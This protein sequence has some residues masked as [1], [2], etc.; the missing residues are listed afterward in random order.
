M[1]L[2]ED[3]PLYLKTQENILDL[4][5]GKRKPLTIGA[6]KRELGT[7]KFLADALEILVFTGVVAEEG[8]ILLPTYKYIGIKKVG[9]ETKVC[10]KCLQEKPLIEF[11]QEWAGSPSRMCKLC[12]IEAQKRRGRKPKSVGKESSTSER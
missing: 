2:D 6:I 9:L 5:K 1:D 7:D 8:S 12:K 4:L 10:G 11:Y 3:S